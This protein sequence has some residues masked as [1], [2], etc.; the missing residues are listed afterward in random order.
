MLSDQS[1][2]GHA[3]LHD[4]AT[5]TA[6]GFKAGAIE[7]P[8]HFSQ[9]TPLLETLWGKA[10]F[11][12]GCF[13]AH[14]QNIVVEG[15][16]VRASVQ[17]S[18]GQTKAARAWAQ[19]EDG[20]SVLHASASLLPFAEPTLLEQ[21]VSK[22]LPPAHLVILR[23]LH[24]GMRGLAD[25]H[26]IMAPNQNMGALYPFSLADK[27]RV[28]TEPSPWYNDDKASP[29]GRAIVPLEM[30]SVLSQYTSEN[31]GFPVRGPAVGLFA[32]LEIRMI[33]GPLF[34]GEPYLIR[35]E[36]IA[37]S[38]SRRTESF[39]VRSRIFERTGT[40]QLAET[41]L[42][43]AVLKHSYAPYETERACVSDGVQG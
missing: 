11:E 38:E 42:N 15:E 29:W 28:I 41:L 34:V 6:L 19:K 25:E 7:G 36:I 18:L 22:L 37:L 33:D 35:R 39:W 4:D 10:W 13:S 2:D 30:V 17:A 23:D 14:F 12:R 24:V 8:T 40:Q 31:A 16:R 5:A 32:D 26:V 1:Y 9:F 3:S 43:H 21:R 27:L 20:V